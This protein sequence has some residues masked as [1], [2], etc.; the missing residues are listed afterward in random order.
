MVTRL[1]FPLIIMNA[2]S[3]KW[4]RAARSLIP[5][6]KNM[7]PQ[8]LLCSYLKEQNKTQA[9]F[10]LQLQGVLWHQ[11]KTRK[12]LRIIKGNLP[13]RDF[14]LL[15]FSLPRLLP[16]I[17]ANCCFRDLRI[18]FFFPSRNLPIWLLSTLIIDCINQWISISSFKKQNMSYSLSY[19]AG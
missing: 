12:C 18:F 8:W 14:F 1:L 5:L 10:I 7:F 19:H 4:R 6:I 9:Y 17:L 13:H 11:K 15:P 3:F 2:G 16:T